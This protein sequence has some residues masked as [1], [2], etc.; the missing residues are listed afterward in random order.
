VGE[1]EISDPVV[2]LQGSGTADAPYI[3]LH[4]DA[5]NKVNLVLSY[6]LRDIDGAADNATQQ[7]NAQYR[8]GG[9][10]PWTNIPG[11]YVADAS[12]GP[13]LATL[14]TPISVTLPAA[15]DNQPQVQIRIMT[16][17]AGGSDEWIG[18]DNISVTGDTP[19]PTNGSSWGQIKALY[20]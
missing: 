19:V 4:I 14:V 5:T 9:T 1:W 3:T 16:T 11:T 15:C 13:S 12:T 2:A 6:D 20:R 10:G 8:L 17:N 7:M 18:I